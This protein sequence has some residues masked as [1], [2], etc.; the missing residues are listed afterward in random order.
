[1]ND[2]ILRSL[3]RLIAA[4][5]NSILA[6]RQVADL[7]DAHDRTLSMALLD[8]ADLLGGANQHATMAIG[9]EHTACDQ[10]QAAALFQRIST[11]APAALVG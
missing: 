1:M 6:L 9:Q 3:R 7:A 8:I 10:L 2:E 4:S 11:I 5:D